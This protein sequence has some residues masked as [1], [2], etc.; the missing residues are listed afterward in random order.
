MVFIYIFQ[1][2]I[3]ICK[4][5]EMVRSSAVNSNDISTLFDELARWEFIL[6][7]IDVN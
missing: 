3:G 5:V 6:E 7:N 1:H 2:L 4:C